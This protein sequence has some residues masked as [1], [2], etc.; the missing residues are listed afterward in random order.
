M[1]EHANETDAA[2][3]QDI[4]NVAFD[5]EVAIAEH[6]AVHNEVDIDSDG[7]DLHV[8]NDDDD[9]ND[10]VRRRNSDDNSGSGRDSDDNSGGS[11][12]YIIDRV[13]RR[14]V[15]V[16][17]IR[18]RPSRAAPAPVPRVE[19]PVLGD[20][21]R[22]LVP[23]DDP[24]EAIAVNDQ[25]RR[26]D[27]SDGVDSDLW[28]IDQLCAA[29]PHAY[30]NRA[31]TLV[32]ACWPT[33]RAVT[34]AEYTKRFGEIFPE[35]AEIGHI[36]HVVIAGGAAARPLGERSTKDGDVDFFIYGIDPHDDRMLWHTV[37]TVVRSLKKAYDA[38]GGL[39]EMIQ[40]MTP[41]VVS[42]A[43]WTASRDSDRA[44]EHKVQI[45]LRAYPSISAI[46][47]AFDVP[48]ACVAYDGSRAYTTTLGAFAHMFRANIVVPA[49]RSTT[50]ETR[51]IKYFG[52]GYALVMPNLDTSKLVKNEKFDL[53]H[54]SLTASV[55]RGN[56]LVGVAAVNEK[57]PSSDYGFAS[58]S[59]A[60]Q[61][62]YRSRFY[63]TVA[64]GVAPLN[65]RQIASGAGQFCVAAVIDN[66][67][68][69]WRRR[70]RRFGK[71][72]QMIPFHKYAGARAG[73]SVD[74]ILPLETLEAIIDHGICGVV[75]HQG[76]ISLRTL[77]NHLSLDSAQLIKFIEVVS[78]AMLTTMPKHIDLVDALAPFRAKLVEKWKAY[79]KEIAWWIKEDPGRQYTASRNPRIE[80]PQ[81]WYGA[82]Y[83]AALPPLDLN[84]QIATLQAAL[85]ARQ[86]V[87]Q[88]GRVFAD[89]TC[90]L[91]HGDLDPSGNNS[92]TL[93]CG[94]AFHW[95]AVDDD[96]T[97][98]ITWVENGNGDC[99]VCRR[100]FHG[101]ADSD[102]DS[103]VDINGNFVRGPHRGRRPVAVAIDW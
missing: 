82:A 56:F 45:I 95:S 50:F 58:K 6:V 78:E 46:L 83:V 72:N 10:R 62:R 55:I 15:P 64:F 79:P 16:Q 61:R 40:W 103:N 65:V 5:E 76:G 75:N 59:S 71:P 33:P 32:P 8:N 52:R 18:G 96:C 31:P 30:L 27:V 93:A 102:V 66:D 81:E 22:K 17:A 73:P 89:G 49:Y 43:A 53:A 77:R 7:Y 23:C 14:H 42:I 11:E 51:L 60:I 19:P 13:H 39:Y 26:A 38:R 100:A 92:V 35:I 12:G 21:S 57:Q 34:Q 47:H 4:G 101:D 54:L 86:V 88:P 68:M 36:P 69:S 99:P 74:D 63:D 25:H 97:G 24:L 90:P 85:E 98:L 29:M 87:K 1:S 20:P 48:A 9:N 2:R 28:S 80:N 41:G 94:H 3:G 70:R 67:G 91:C 37:A 84:G 44:V